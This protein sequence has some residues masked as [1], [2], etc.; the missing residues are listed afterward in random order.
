M[1]DRRSLRGQPRRP[2]LLTE[3]ARPNLPTFHKCNLAQG[4]TDNRPQSNNQTL[5]LTCKELALE[6]DHSNKSRID[7]N[8]HTE[9]ICNESP[10]G[11]V[12]NQRL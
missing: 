8:P 11:A 3:R 5:W 9:R 4:R 2:S 12:A 1:A 6:L 10:E 7:P